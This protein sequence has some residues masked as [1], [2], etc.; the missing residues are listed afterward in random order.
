LNAPLPLHLRVLP[1]RFAICRLPG[2]APLPTWV[3]HAG[4]THYSVTRTPDEL[5]VVCDEDDVPPSVDRAERGWRALEL[6]GPIPFETTGVIAGLT[7]P[8]AVAGVPVFVLC[9]YDTDY[10]LVRERDLERAL[11][12]LEAVATVER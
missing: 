11:S 6:R 2:D 7:A 8:L 12:A 10:L 5:S 3:F 1:G 9:T 4:A